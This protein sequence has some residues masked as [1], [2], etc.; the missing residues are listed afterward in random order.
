MK[1]SISGFQ[2]EVADDQLLPTLTRHARESRWKNLLSLYMQLMA[3]FEIKLAAPTVEFKVPLLNLIADKDT[4]AETEKAIVQMNALVLGA[5]VHFPE[6]LAQFRKLTEEDENR[7]SADMEDVGAH[8]PVSVRENTYTQHEQ[9]YYLRLHYYEQSKTLKEDINSNQDMLQDTQQ[10]LHLLQ[11]DLSKALTDKEQSALKLEEAYQQNEEDKKDFIKLEAEIVRLEANY[12][13]L[14]KDFESQE[15]LYLATAKVLEKCRAHGKDLGLKMEEL[16]CSWRE[17]I[18]LLDHEK[19]KTRDYEKIIEQNREEYS[20]LEA[21]NQEVEMKVKGMEEEINTLT[22]RAEPAKLTDQQYEEIRIQLDTK[23]QEIQLLMDKLQD[24][25]HELDDVLTTIRRYMEDLEAKNAEIQA[26]QQ[27]IQT[28]S[29]ALD[30]PSLALEFESILTAD[31][32]IP[33]SKWRHQAS[34]LQRR[35]TRVHEIAEHKHTIVYSDYKDLH[36]RYL[37]MDESI[38]TLEEQLEANQTEIENRNAKL[39]SLQLRHNILQTNYQTTLQHLQ[40]SENTSKAQVEE[41]KLQRTMFNDHHFNHK[42]LQ[43]EHQI[44]LQSLKLLENKIVLWEIEKLK[45]AQTISTLQA[46]TQTLEAK[47]KAL[48]E[49]LTDARQSLKKAEIQW[50][51]KG[52]LQQCTFNELQLQLEASATEVKL[53]KNQ[54]TE[55]QDAEKRKADNDLVVMSAVHALGM[56][57]EQRKNKSS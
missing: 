32:S 38:R 33:L 50:T 44:T 57:E 45:M 2:S 3:H 6:G 37:Q 56:R 34:G 16:E 17:E 31:M 12:G 35:L 13:K 26:L 20:L 18:R 51:E 39:V 10:E 9:Y 40:S 23:D 36:S 11:A 22:R 27:Q 15:E 30:Q 19:V 14:Q 25:R 5:Y 7:L 24:T 28:D 47:A 53:L 52:E 54:L 42:A 8:H 49:K 4:G 41:L 43:T 46:Q 48:R 55:A 21:V 1:N 29:T